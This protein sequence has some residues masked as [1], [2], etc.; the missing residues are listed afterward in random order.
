MKT[1]IFIIVLFTI[2]LGLSLL[3]GKFNAPNDGL[4]EIGLPF[5][6]FRAFSGKCLHCSF[7]TGFLIKGFVG[8]M[9]TILGITLV[10]HLLK[11]KTNNTK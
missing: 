11:T 6:F 3:L 10:W 5:T 8:N 4:T 9:V 1:Y 7:Q 2:W